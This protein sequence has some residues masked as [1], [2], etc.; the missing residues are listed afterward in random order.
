MTAG[1]RLALLAAIGAAMTGLTDAGLAVLQ[2]PVH[3]RDGQVALAAA[4]SLGA[5]LLWLG[6]V[7]LVRAGEVPRTCVWLVLAVALAMRALTFMAPPLLSTDVF[8]YVWDGRVQTAGISPYRFVPAAP[9]LTFLRDD[10]VFPRI[11][12][13]DSAVTIYPPAAQALFAAVALVAPGLAGMRAVM[14]GFDLLAIGGLLL[15]LRVAGRPAPEVLIYAWAPLPVWEF[16]GNAHIDA[17]AAGLLPLALLAAA[18]ERR[19]LAGVVLAIATLTKFL[20]GVVLP[21]V[22]RRGDWRLPAASALLAAAL[23]APYVASGANVAGFLP[24]Y[25][26]EEGIGS[27]NGIFLLQL[28]AR[29]GLPSSGA[30]AVYAFVVLAGLGWLTWRAAAG[31]WPTEAG[32]RV[33]AMAGHAVSLAAFLLAAV[34]PHYPWYFGWLVPL[35]CLAPRGFALWLI[36]AAPLLVLGPIEHLAIPALVYGPAG[37]VLFCPGRC[38]WTKVFASFFKKKRLLALKRQ[39]QRDERK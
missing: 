25:L 36:A 6:A 7:R 21:A 4:L 37:L 39:G 20:P 24:G 12:R 22:W 14:A 5:G 29:A 35:T 15:A 34:S 26:S 38:E 33:S 1:R 16:A 8:R 23:Y 28:A 10:A 13:A 30:A 31:T 3:E 2:A 27:G 11:N 32:A 18:R 19:A 17:V 9:E